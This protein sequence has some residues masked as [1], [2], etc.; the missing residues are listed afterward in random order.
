M[1]KQQDTHSDWSLIYEPEHVF[2]VQKE[3]SAN[4]DKYFNEFVE[5]GNDTIAS[6]ERFQQCETLMGVTVKH[7][8]SAPKQLDWATKFKEILSDAINHFENDQNDSRDKYIALLDEENLAEAQDDL[9]AFKNKT[10][11]TECPIIRKTL[12]SSAKKLDKYRQDFGLANPVQ[13][14]EVIV[15][16]SNFTR[17]YQI[18]FKD[19][20]DYDKIDCYDSLAL[21]ELR[22]MGYPGV[23]GYGISSHIMFKLNP[24]LFSN[25][26]SNAIWALWYLTA[27]KEFGCQKGSGSEFLITEKK[28]NTADHNYYYPSDLYTWYALCIYR[29]IC[30]KADNHGVRIDPEYRYVIVD[31]FLNYI[32]KKHCS[33]NSVLKSQYANGGLGYA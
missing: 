15:F 11:R 16:L 4:F 19:P 20:D 1:Y 9:A 25:R 8:S 7:K 30:M 6:A 29:N 22:G 21:H 27:K 33:D 13:L 18:L 2:S 32:V 10:L 17:K 12:Y 23:I 3:I 5:T 14:Y 31:V 24:R 26:S 28:S